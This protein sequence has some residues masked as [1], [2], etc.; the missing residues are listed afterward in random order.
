M[1][2][3]H[4]NARCIDEEAY[5]RT[6][7]QIHTHT[8]TQHHF[9]LSKVYQTLE[10]NRVPLSYRSATVPAR[11]LNR[12]RFN[13][14][15]LWIV[16]PFF[17]Q[18]SQR[19]SHHVSLRVQLFFRLRFPSSF[20][21]IPNTVFL[22]RLRFALFPFRPVFVQRHRSGSSSNSTS[23]ICFVPGLLKS[24]EQDQSRLSLMRE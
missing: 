2:V 14:E 11:A 15:R 19:F 9:C 21:W 23:R 8:H 10:R 7:R 16:F 3:V 24:E 1:S 4:E 13:F 6:V 5:H 12:T 20:C 18:L 22:L 17:L